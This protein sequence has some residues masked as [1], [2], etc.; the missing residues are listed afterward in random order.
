VPL[1]RGQPLGD[2]VQPAH[3][4]FEYPR[5]ASGPYGRSF[6]FPLLGGLVSE[7]P[8]HL[9]ANPGQIR[10]QLDEY[11]RGQAFALPYKAEQDVL[12]ADVIVTELE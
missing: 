11:L 5:R 6:F 2:R 1:D 7:L 4:P 9:L 3:D 8:Q 12:G 10:A